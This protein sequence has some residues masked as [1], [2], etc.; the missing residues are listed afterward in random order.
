MFCHRCGARVGSELR[1]CPNCGQ[2]LPTFAT[3]LG[4]ANPS[5]LWKSPSRAEASPGRWMSE[6]WALVQADLGNYVLIGLLFFLL[7][8]VP[9][10]Q[11][12]L[13]RAS[14]SIP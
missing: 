8:G 1:F 3:S 13:S 14:T 2:A 7:S 5:A 4:G 10:I 11:G 12:V 9:L 6:G